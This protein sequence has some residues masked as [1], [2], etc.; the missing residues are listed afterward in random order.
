M[1]GREGS[2]CSDEHRRSAIVISLLVA[3]HHKP[4]VSHLGDLCHTGLWLCVWSRGFNQQSSLYV[5]I[6][7]SKTSLHIT[8]HAIHNGVGHVTSLSINQ[9]LTSLRMAHT[10]E[11]FR[12]ESRSARTGL[13]D[14]STAPSATPFS[15]WPV[16]MNNPQ[17][18]LWSKVYQQH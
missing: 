3:R 14:G 15:K 1:R 18:S 2:R 16:F 12:T 9:W 13:K 6:R 5:S 7:W 17:L 10:A 11:S 8:W 4:C